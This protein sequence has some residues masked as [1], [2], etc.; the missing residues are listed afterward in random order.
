MNR[1]KFGLTLLGIA[2]ALALTGS[3]AQAEPNLTIPNSIFDFG[4]A[5]QKSKLSHSF[6]LKSTGTDSLIIQKVVPG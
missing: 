2:A 5:P 4:F 3:P 1:V 6:W